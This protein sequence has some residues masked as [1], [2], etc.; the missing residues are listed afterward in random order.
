MP[1][2]VMTYS[3]KPLIDPPR[4]HF[5]SGVSRR[6][7]PSKLAMYEGDQQADPTRDYYA[8]PSDQPTPHGTPHAGGVHHGNRKG[9]VRTRLGRSQHVRVQDFEECEGET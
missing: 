9:G 2:G 7:R 4:Q 8:K 1:G 6:R 5:Y 3:P